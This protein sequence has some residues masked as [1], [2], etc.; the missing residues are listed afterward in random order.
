MEKNLI[1]EPSEVKKV[2]ADTFAHQFRKRRTTLD[3]LSPF[4]K[5]IYNRQSENEEAYTPLMESFTKEEWLETIRELSVKSAAGP[6][7]INYRILKKLPLDF[8]KFILRFYN[9]CYRT[10]CNPTA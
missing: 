6:S 3:N 4:W 7:E 1:L 9:V 2:A 5:E 10:S 8:I